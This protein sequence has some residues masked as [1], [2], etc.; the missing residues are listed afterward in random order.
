MKGISTICNICYAWCG[1][2]A[3]SEGGRLISVEGDPG[4]PTTGGF[5]CPKGRAL[6]EIVYG[7]RRLLYPMMRRRG[8]LHRITWDEAFKYAASEIGRI[9]R[10][11]GPTAIAGYLGAPICGEAGEAFRQFLAAIGS[12]YSSEPGDMCFWPHTLGYLYTLGFKPAPDI[13]NTRLLV[14]WGSSITDCSLRIG[15]GVSYGIPPTSLASYIKRR[16]IKLMVVDPR[17]SALARSSDLWIPVRPGTDAALA[18]ALINYIIEHDIY[19]RDFVEE[20]TVGFEELRKR[21]SGY[22]IEWAERVTWARRSIITRFAEEYATTKPATIRLGN[23]VEP[24]SNSF[25]IARAIAILSAIT[26]NVCTKGGDAYYPVPR[27]F[28]APHVP[29]F[30]G[31]GVPEYPLL[32]FVPFGTIVDKILSGERG[33][34]R[35]LLIYHG[36]PILAMPGEDRVER[37]LKKLEFILVYDIELNET[38]KL[39][40]LVLPDASDMERWGVSA[41]GSPRGGMILLRRPVLSPRG[42]SMPVMDFE[43]KLAEMLGLAEKYPWRTQREWVEYKLKASNV[44]IEDFGDD[45]YL[46]VKS[47]PDYGKF[48]RMGFPTSSHKVEIYSRRLEEL[49]LDPLPGHV[50]PAE[51]P[52]STPWLYR[53]FPLVCTTRKQLAYVNTRF[54]D[55]ASLRVLHDGPEVLISHEDATWRGISSGDLVIIETARGHVEMKA[56]VGSVMKGVAIA[57]FGWSGRAN[58]NRITPGSPRDPAT[59][60]PPADEFLCD[61]RRLDVL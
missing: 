17:K 48:R 15:E 4:H 44:D 6:P 55:V 10:E 36:N 59:G 58:V 8:E 26:G 24:H 18:L 46:Y 49:G 61:V 52:L 23:G 5:I 3:R 43:Y 31:F 35:A 25:N 30:R 34:P 16:G 51:S 56:I 1:I 13:P 27:L 40:H 2:I 29:G 14:V 38:A 45:S 37:A 60:S 22:T 9:L 57:D 39:A 47:P 20:Y 42:E 21:I 41:M 19:D 7:R 11:H 53:R 33:S 12:P 54:R 50:E 28:R 32:R